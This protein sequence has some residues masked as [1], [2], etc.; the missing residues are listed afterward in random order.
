MCQNWS[1]RQKK[2]YKGLKKVGGEAAGFFKSALTC[3]YDESFPNKVSFLA[4]AAREIDGGIRDIFSFKMAKKKGAHSLIKKSHINSILAVLKAEERDVLAKEWHSISKKLHKYAHRH[5]I[6]KQPRRFEEFESLWDRYEEILLKLVGSFYAIINRIDILMQIGEI[7]ETACGVLLNLIR[8]KPY[9]EYFSRNVKNLNWFLPLLRNNVF[10][11]NN[12]QFDDKGNA[13]FWNVLP[14]LEQVSLQIKSLGSE[15]QTKYSKELVKIIDNTVNYSLKLKR[16]KGKKKIN[17]FHIWWF[18]VKIINNIPTELIVRENLFNVEQ[19]RKWLFEFM[20]PEMSGDLAVIDITEKLLPKFLDNKGTVEFAED[21]INIITSIKKGGRKTPFLDRNEALLVYSF[22]SYWIHDAFKKH[23]VKIGEVCSIDTIY[24]LAD[25]LRLALEYEQ[26]DSFI[27]LK[28]KNNIYRVKIERLPEENI[29]QDEIGFKKNNYTI[30]IKQFSPKQLEKIDF[31]KDIWTSANTE[32]EIFLSRFSIEAED[33]QTFS[34]RIEKKLPSNIKWQNVQDFEKEINNLFD[35]LY[36]DYSQVWCRS[37]AKGPEYPNHANTLL[38]IW[39]R[40][41]LLS[42]CKTDKE[43]GNKILKDFLGDK[44]KFPIFKRLVILCV[45]KLW[46][47]YKELAK[48]I[49]EGIPDILEE[50]DYE[51]E[52]FDLLKNHNNEFGPDII[53]K[54]KELIENIP[55]YYQKENLEDYWRYKWYSPLKDNEEFKESYIKAK[56]KIKPKD[57]KPYTPVR[58]TVK[59]GF[60]GHKSPLPKEKILEMPIAELVKFLNEFKGADSWG[61]TFEGK[62]DKEG[63]A[64]TLR[65]AVTENPEKFVKE[66]DLFYNAPYFYVN[67][68]LWGLRD[69]FNAGK[70]FTPLWGEIFRFSLKYVKKLKEAFESQR[71]DSNRGKYIS[72][73]DDIVNL[74]EAGSEDDSRAFSAEHFDT[75]KQIFDVAT[76]L[77]KVE[78]QPDTQRDAITYALNT[79][80]GRIVMSFIVFSL[81]VKRVTEEEEKDWGKNNYERFF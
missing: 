22:S 48:E 21:I 42:K 4:H 52:I 59:S 16:E 55:Q 34:E 53:A 44:Y 7:N 5:G 75:V 33:K 74:I 58:F 14:Y 68:I 2:I 15:E 63:L 40:D 31:D 11:P 65:K 8:V 37:L 1:E 50:P 69:A 18:F 78:L 60:I 25:R 28:I 32:P 35:D 66:I 46:G 6:W 39:I 20:D 67:H 17:H 23:S 79:T 12:I 81:R 45:D 76:R 80:F 73:V 71:G 47:N 51:V 56:E 10:Q 36:E 38:T 30:T 13:L 72:V 49:L 77:L 70:D 26:Q 64:E 29:K 27:D 61:G 43:S 9:E 3:Y 24:T 19:F 62:P 41:I 57:D 54:L